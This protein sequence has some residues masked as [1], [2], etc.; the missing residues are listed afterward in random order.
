M[1]LIGA[2]APPTLAATTRLTILG[3]NLNGAGERACLEGGLPFRLGYEFTNCRP[4]WGN[5]MAE[6][7]DIEYRFC[8]ACLREVN[9]FLPGPGGRPNARCPL[10]HSLQRHRFLALLLAAY[11]PE[12]SDSRYVLEVAPSR[13]VTR[14]LRRASRGEYVGI[15]IDPAADGRTVR[16]AADLCRA[17]FADGVFDTS[18][19]FHVFEHIPDDMSAMRE[20]S[21]LIAPHGI[22]FIQNPWRPS[23]PTQEDPDASPEERTQRFGQADHVRI[24]GSDFD[25]RLKSAGLQPRCLFPGRVISA[26]T[27]EVMAITKHPPIWVVNGEKSRLRSLSDSE[28]EADARIRVQR[29]LNESKE[30]PLSV[31]GEQIRRKRRKMRWLPGKGRTR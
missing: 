23:A 1:R 18:V 28:F 27:M 12:I 15:D 31:R 17:P 21:R 24:Y 7:A 29:T 16:V 4:D 14:M 30:W 19:C 13:N 8:P 22:G 26:G 5:S 20:Y 25:D 10:C 9:A 2:T 6:I 11:A 3:V